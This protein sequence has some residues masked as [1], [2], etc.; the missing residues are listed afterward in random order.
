MEEV[1]SAESAKKKKPARR[2]IS[3]ESVAVERQ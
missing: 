2:R 3:G 1:K